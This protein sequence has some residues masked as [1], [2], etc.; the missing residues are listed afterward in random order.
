MRFDIDDWNDFVMWVSGAYVTVTTAVN[1]F[2]S[3]NP[4]INKIPSGYSDNGTK[5]CWKFGDYDDIRQGLSGLSWFYIDSRV[6]M[7][8]YEGK[9]NTESSTGRMWVSIC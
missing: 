1:E 9:F 6:D 4:T 2:S 7:R 5:L 8:G 3:Y